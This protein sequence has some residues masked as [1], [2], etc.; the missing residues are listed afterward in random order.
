[1]TSRTQ[2]GIGCL[3]TVKARLQI[4][5]YYR[6]DWTWSIPR[7]VNVYKITRDSNPGELT[8]G[9]QC[10]CMFH[11]GIPATYSYIARSVFGEHAIL[12]PINLHKKVQG[13]YGSIK[14]V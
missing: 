7:A 1:M 5:E 13:G 9:A 8:V 11:K 14:A 12:L 2:D 10:S 4:D 3:I 6:R